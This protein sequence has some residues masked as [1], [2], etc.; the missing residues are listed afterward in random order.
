MCF[1]SRL[2]LVFPSTIHGFFC[3]SDYGFAGF[4][5][6]LPYRLGG[7]FCFF[8]NGFGSLLCFLSCCFHSVFNCFP[9]FLRSVLYVLN[10]AVLAEGSQR[11]RGNQSSN[12]IHDF[13]VPF[14][15]LILF[16]YGIECSSPSARTTNAR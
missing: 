1:S 16:Y 3:F 14:L 12:Q 5:R 6:F 10:H 7:L 8:A 11:A 15:Q 9:C 2:G 13:H 4:L